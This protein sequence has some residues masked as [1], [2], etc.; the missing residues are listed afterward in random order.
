MNLNEAKEILNKNGFVL[1]ERF[2]NID[3]IR[4]P[5]WLWAAYETGDTS[6]LED[7]EIVILH[8]FEKDHKKHHLEA[9]EEPNFYRTNDVTDEGGM[10]YTVQVFEDRMDEDYN[11]YRNPFNQMNRKR[12]KQSVIKKELNKWFNL[13]SQMDKVK[14]HHYEIKGNT[15][16]EYTKSGIDA[17]WTFEMNKNDINVVVSWINRPEWQEMKPVEFEY[18]LDEYD[19]YENDVKE[20]LTCTGKFH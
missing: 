6:N 2:E 7:E 3:E 12:Q 19:D 1:K 11:F 4:V 8:I 16:I 13:L 14:T 20:F 9:N 10:C 15:I 5:E 17:V 18:T